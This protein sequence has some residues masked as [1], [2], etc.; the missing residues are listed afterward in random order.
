MRISDWSSDVCSSD[1]SG[2]EVSG[3]LFVDCSGFR[4]LLLGQ[5]LGVPWHD[6]SEW[7]PCDRALARAGEGTAPRIP[8]TRCTAQRGGWTWRIP[9]QQRTGNG[10]VLASGFCSEEEAERTLRGAIDGAARGEPRLLRFQAGRR[11]MGWAGNVA[12]IGLSSGFLEPLE[13]TS[14]FLIQAAVTDLAALM[15]RRGERSEERRVGKEGVST[16]RYGWSP[17]HLKNKITI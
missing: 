6:G 9:L 14:I 3:D 4:S 11:G 8:L 7:L 10:H 17:D 16:C 5:T 2:A 15:P 12:A 13:S 1:L